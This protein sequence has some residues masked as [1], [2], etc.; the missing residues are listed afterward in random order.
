MSLKPR[1][2]VF[3]TVDPS[4]GLET[5]KPIGLNSRHERRLMGALMSWYGW[6]WG[7]DGNLYSPRPNEHAWGARG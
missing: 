5:A 4:P 1:V 6:K 3:D 7:E 2:P